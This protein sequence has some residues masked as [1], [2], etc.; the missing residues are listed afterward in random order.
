VP[1]REI[2]N[3]K[4]ADERSFLYAE[5]SSMSAH[6]TSSALMELFPAGGEW[7]EADYFPLS[8]RGRLVSEG[9]IEV[10]ELPTDFHQLILLRLTLALHTS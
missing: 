1:P 8:E 7:T 9:E 10:I 5:G 3:R 2:A 6:G 4:P